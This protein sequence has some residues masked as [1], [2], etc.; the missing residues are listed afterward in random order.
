MGSTI[1][2]RPQTAGIRP[3]S[4]GSPGERVNPLKRVTTS[5]R[6][7]V[8]FLTPSLGRGGAERWIVSLARWLQPVIDV[9][10]IAC[11]SYGSTYEALRPEVQRWAP[12]AI[13][14]ESR[15]AY[16]ALLQSADV[17][18][19][20]GYAALNNFVPRDLAARII[21]VAHGS[22]PWTAEHVA[23][24]EPWVHHWAAVSEACR[25]AF[26]PHL[27]ER[28][29]VIHNGADIERTTPIH[30]RQAT[31]VAWG[32]QPHQ[33]A[34][35][36]LGRFSNEKRAEALA[37]AIKLLPPHYVGIMAG[38]GWKETEAREYC[39]RVAGDRVKFVGFTSHV[40]DALAASDVWINVSPAEGFSLS[41][42][43]AWLAGVPCVST[44]TG[45]IPEL[46]AL[47]GQL[48]TEVP[49]GADAPLIASAIREAQSCRAE[50]M[51]HRA[52]Q[53]AWQHFTAPAMAARWIKYLSSV[54]HH[55]SPLAP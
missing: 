53:L 35:T 39:Q 28:V 4:N 9:V 36:Y 50:L 8:A 46:Q 2:I 7:R 5:G 13:M 30:G 37:D 19:A 52:R 26:P 18:I 10:G 44:P 33:I 29:T 31:R 15:T 14:Q 55:S 38:D 21:Y 40:G 32:V 25:P 27:Q 48:V 47:H 6:L 3:E 42:I 49:I 17:V 23:W 16:D 12:V 24:A 1:R 51:A 54:C 43:E 45:A 41:L 22:G 34:V 20:W 11:S